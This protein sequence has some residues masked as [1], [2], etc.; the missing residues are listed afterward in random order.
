MTPVIS[1]I[2][3]VYNV[4]KFLPACIESILNQKYHKWELILVDDGSTDTSGQI[5]DKYA[6]SNPKIKVIHQSNKGVSA[7]RNKGLEIASG[8][9]TGFL[10]SDDFL[11]INTY[12][13]MIPLMEQNN[14]DISFFKF[15]FLGKR[16]STKNSLN[17]G[18]DLLILTGESRFSKTLVYSGSS[19]N[20]IYKTDLI[21]NQKFSQDYKLAEDTLFLVGALAKSRKVLLVNNEFY[22]RRIRNE[23]ASH[24]SY[25]E[26]WTKLPQVTLEIISKIMECGQEYHAIAEYVFWTKTSELINSFFNNYKQYGDDIKKLQKPLQAQYKQLFSNRYLPLARKGAISL[27]ITSPFL[28]YNIKKIYIKLKFVLGILK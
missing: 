1:I 15:Y 20:C 26:R 6:S 12:S 3:P 5:C 16:N 17:N 7:A 23:S 13:V 27:F 10:D 19:C 9:Y 21:Q 2:V 18:M 22:M 25:D 24:S 8:Q 14:I 28:F 4:E 11:D